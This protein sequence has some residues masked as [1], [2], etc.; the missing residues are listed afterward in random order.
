[1]LRS[2]IILTAWI[3]CSSIDVNAGGPALP[4][5]AERAA[6][7]RVELA[8]RIRAGGVRKPMEGA[9]AAQQN[10]YDVL[11]YSLELDLR[12]PDVQ[13]LLGA[14]TSELLVTEGPL[15]TLLLDLRETMAVDSVFVD[16]RTAPFVQEVYDLRIGTPS[17]ADG[18]TTRVRVHYQGHPVQ[19]GFAAFVWSLHQG[20]PLIWTLSEPNGARE[21]WPCKDRP[22]DKAERV[23][24]VIHTPDWMTAISNGLLVEETIPGPGFRRFA[25]R[26]D[27]PIAT[28]LVSLCAGTYERLTDRYVRPDGDTLRIEHYVYPEHREEAREDFSITPAAIRAFEGLFGP[29][30]FD[31]EKYGHTIFPWGGAMEHQTNT[32]YGAGLIRGDHAYDWILAH[33]LAHQWWGDMISPADWRDIWLNEGFASYA[34]ALWAEHLGGP[35]MLRRYMREVQ[36]VLEPSGTVYDPVNLFD[37]SDV[38]NKGAWVL[39]MLRG[40]VGDSLFFAVLEEYRARTAYRSTTTVEFRA[41]AQEVCGRD[42]D[43]LFVPWVYGGGR[44]TYAVS[45]LP[46]GNETTPGVAIHV[47]QGGDGVPFPMPVDLEIQTEGGGAIRRRVFNDPDRQDFEIDLPAAPIGVRLDPDEW[48]LK[49]VKHESYGLNITTTRIAPAKADS[50]YETFLVA[51]GGE[52]P[53]EWSA[54][55]SLPFTMALEAATGRL[56]GT[57]PD[58]GLYEIF[59]RVRDAADLMDTQRLILAVDAALP[60][61]SAF[62]PSTTG[63]TLHV[64]PVPARAWVSI[65][66]EGPTGIELRVTVLDL[67]GRRVREVWNAPA[68][69]RSIVWDGRDERGRTVPSGIYFARVEAGRER[70]VRRLVW[71][72]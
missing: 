8:R 48:I 42:L 66:L 31:R 35:E 51:R 16:G 7:Q 55:E 38:Y 14:M 34:E 63:V 2:P 9:R 56:H 26:H 5:P 4:D 70:I 12:Q 49:F 29:Y 15:D 72:R 3:L 40:A 62:I 36:G 25:W 41:I 45:F 27:Y 65:S 71:L 59:V 24:V 54:L 50:A 10:R 32:S 52:S 28:Y 47:D 17:L 46:I 18:D 58:S 30:P 69:G 43:F 23:S 68:P 53:H 67:L 21:W 57:A 64:G 20:A 13:W 61:D 39:H 11:S 22:D 19:T 37:P 60:A 6:F 1:M 33:E 44:P